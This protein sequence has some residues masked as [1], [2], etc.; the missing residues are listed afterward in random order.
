MLS[1][2][3]LLNEVNG[4]AIEDLLLRDGVVEDHAEVEGADWLKKSES[5][6]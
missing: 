4:T 3:E 2:H 5:S 6:K 1:G